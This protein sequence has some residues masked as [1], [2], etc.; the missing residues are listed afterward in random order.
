MTDFSRFRRSESYYAVLAHELTHWT[1]AKHRLDRQLSTRFGFEAYAME[2]LIAELGA[3]FTCAR[4]G[5]AT[6]ARR[7]HTPHVASWLKA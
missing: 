4:L 6:E 1:R 5:I 2:E 7:D 3:A